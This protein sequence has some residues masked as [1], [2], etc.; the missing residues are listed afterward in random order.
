MGRGRG[1]GVSRGRGRGGGPVP[2]VPPVVPPV[3]PPATGLRLEAGLSMYRHAVCNASQPSLYR[4]KPN[5]VVTVFRTSLH[6]DGYGG[7]GGGG[8][9]H[10]QLI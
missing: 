8:G 6:F 10:Q 9:L 3:E 5:R 1:C 2:P 4:N 7:G